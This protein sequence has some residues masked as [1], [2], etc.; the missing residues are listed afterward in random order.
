MDI[1]TDEQLLVHT[2][3]ERRRWKKLSRYRP[4]S[5]SSVGVRSRCRKLEKTG[6]KLQRSHEKYVQSRYLVKKTAFS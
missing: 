5:S 6:K 4:I 3:A 2:V 1:K